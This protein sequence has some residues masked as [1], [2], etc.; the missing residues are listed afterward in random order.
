MRVRVTSGGKLRTHVRR[1][2]NRTSG[3]RIDGTP[4]RARLREELAIALTPDLG[5]PFKR[6]PSGFADPCAKHDFVAER[7][8]RLVVDFVSQHNPADLLL[9]FGAGY[10]SPMRG[11]DIL[12]PA[13]VNSVVYVI[14]LVDIAWQ[15]RNDHFESSGGHRKLATRSSKAQNAAEHRLAIFLLALA[16]AAGEV[17]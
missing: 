1:D 16:V 11:G 17:Y 6:E 15:N 4:E 3:L 14:L 8:G 2:A 10:C 13:Q 7:G 9:S 12:H 5:E